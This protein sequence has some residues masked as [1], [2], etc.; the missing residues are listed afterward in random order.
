MIERVA[1][2]KSIK[3]SSRSG[4]SL[5]SLEKPSNISTDFSPPRPPP[6]PREKTREVQP[7]F[8]DNDISLFKRV[9]QEV[10]DLR[11]SPSD[12]TPTGIETIWFLLSRFDRLDPLFGFV[13]EGLESLEEWAAVFEFRELKQFLDG[14]RAV[15]EATI[16]RLMTLVKTPASMGAKWIFEVC[17]F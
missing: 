12:D 1:S 5:R 4:D 10:I 16:A 6:L 8:D 17:V 15:F 9:V 7:D 11:H 2:L 14:E 13:E 3:E